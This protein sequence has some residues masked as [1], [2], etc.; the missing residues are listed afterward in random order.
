MWLC[1]QVSGS[2]AD[3]VSDTLMELLGW[4]CASFA[5]ILGRHSHVSVSL[6]VVDETMC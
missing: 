2:H 3:G 6:A 1:Q 4:R 5:H